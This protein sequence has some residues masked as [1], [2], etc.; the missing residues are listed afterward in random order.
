L[1]LK[2]RATPADGKLSVTI[3][4][5]QLPEQGNQKQVFNILHNQRYPL[6]S[7]EFLEEDESQNWRILNDEDL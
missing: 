3:L 4:T 5:G 7:L 2:S 6:L 1:A